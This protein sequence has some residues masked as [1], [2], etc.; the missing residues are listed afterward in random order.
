LRDIQPAVAATKG[1]EGDALANAM[2]ANDAEVANK[3]RSEAQLGELTSQIRVVEGY[4]EL[5]TGKVERTL[6]SR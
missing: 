5:D 3:S 4:Y 2:H 6:D 1:K